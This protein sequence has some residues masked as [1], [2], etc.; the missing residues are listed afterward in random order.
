[1]NADVIGSNGPTMIN[2]Y[3]KRTCVVV[4]CHRIY[5]FPKFVIQLEVHTDISIAD[6]M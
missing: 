6:V 3:Q 2:R 1:M 4:G 5:D